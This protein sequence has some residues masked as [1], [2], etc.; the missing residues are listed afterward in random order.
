MQKTARQD[1]SI[2][3]ASILA[4]RSSKPCWREMKGRLELPGVESGARREK[5]Q[6]AGNPSRMLKED[7]IQ[8]MLPA[9]N[10]KHHQLLYCFA[11]IRSVVLRPVR[12]SHETP[13]RRRT[14]IRSLETGQ[15]LAVR[16]SMRSFRGR[17]CDQ[18]GLRR[19][20]ELCSCWI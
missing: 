4:S 15:V 5:D 18:R 16:R 20:R 3:S 19:F 7:S 6:S 2:R 8:P 11:S 9:L 17:R 13:T 10:R 1:S 14:T 12:V